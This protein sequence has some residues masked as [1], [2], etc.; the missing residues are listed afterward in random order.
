MPRFHFELGSLNEEKQQAADNE[1]TN[2]VGGGKD[3]RMN[4]D[5]AKKPAAARQKRVD[6][7]DR[8]PCR[9]KSTH[10]QATLIRQAEVRW[11]ACGEVVGELHSTQF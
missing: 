6:D 2:R 4:D 3:E 10:E 8:Q 5:L 7:G 9:Q 1:N 11:Y